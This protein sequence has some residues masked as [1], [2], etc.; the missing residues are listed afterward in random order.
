MN[1]REMDV[2]FLVAT[3]LGLV[4]KGVSRVRFELLE[5]PKRP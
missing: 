5:E 1:D 4:G 2:S 3:R